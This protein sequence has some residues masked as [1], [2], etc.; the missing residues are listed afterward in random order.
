MFL[1]SYEKLDERKKL[2]KLLKKNAVVV[3]GKRLN[4]S[5]L[6][7][8]I[9]EQAAANEVQI[10]EKAI[11][12]LLSLSGSD[13]MRLHT[14]IEKLSLYAEDTKTIDEEIV[15]R[16]TARSLEQNIFALVEKV[17]ERRMDE[18]LRIYYDLRRQN[19]EPI[20]IL[21]L[22]AG[23]FRLIYQV[24]ELLKRG[25]GQQQI[26]GSLKV[27]PFR[28]RLASG[29]AR[30]FTDEEL[31]KIMQLLAE[32]DFQ[33]KTGKRDRDVAIELFLFKLGD[34]K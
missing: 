7:V 17:V 20:K 21:S 23:Q 1:G 15:E 8:W 28:V 22:F 30:S 34:L 25:Y 12:L 13:L 31:E 2:T 16:L 6:K 11:E 4:E 14:E 18:A 27:H 24:K 33:I 9:R 32:S 29:H 19:E 3:E 5:D 10:D 26:A